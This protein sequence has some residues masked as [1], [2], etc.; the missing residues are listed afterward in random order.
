MPDYSNYEKEV[1]RTA[2]GD[3][4]AII[5]RFSGNVNL[6]HAAIGMSTEAN[7]FLD[8]IKKYLMYGKDI[9]HVNLIEEMGDIMW[10]MALASNIL[11][12]SF[13]EI[14]H[15]NITKL[16]E[17]YK[18]KWIKEEALN[19]DTKKELSSFYQPDWYDKHY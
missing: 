1:M 2:S 19:R 3:E 14:Q 8:T 16:K 17:R 11:G 9:D 18:G 6:T 4:P 7:E 15:R 5:K 10:Y 12:V 13:D